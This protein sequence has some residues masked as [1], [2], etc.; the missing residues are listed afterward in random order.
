[1]RQPIH[2]ARDGVPIIE[3][4]QRFGP[5]KQDMFVICDDGVSYQL[6]K[7]TDDKHWSLVARWDGDERVPD[8]SRLPEAVEVFLTNYVQE[9]RGEWY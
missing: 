1:M 4:E 6:Q 3:S 7:F 2:D 8:P 5:D 9:M